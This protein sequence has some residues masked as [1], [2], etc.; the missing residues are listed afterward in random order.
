MAAEGTLGEDLDLL[1]R[2]ARAAGDAALPYFNAGR[3]T[4]ARVSW[5]E[6]NSPV[7]EADHAANDALAAVLRGARPGYQWVSEETADA[8]DRLSASHVFVVDP[9]DGTRAFIAGKLQW[10]VSAALVVE[11]EPALGVIHAP[12]LGVTYVARR[13][14]GATRNGQ[15]IRHSDRARLDRASAA[16]PKPTLESLE[17]AAGVTLDHAPKVP[18]LALRLALAAEGRVDLALASTGAH[19]WDVAA[20]DV[21]LR[22]AGGVLLDLDGEPLVYNRPSL[23]RGPLCAGT[24]ALAAAAAR[25][26]AGIGPS[27]PRR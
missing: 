15:P 18:S 19:D 10:S 21:I 16:G 13:G 25:A 2:A 17:T 8:L 1:L 27:A 7:S 6:G 22:E 12:A 24:P 9:I 4:S 23:R 5:K 11:G 3:E 26:L 20:A 14:G